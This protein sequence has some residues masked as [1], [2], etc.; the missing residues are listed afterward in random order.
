MQQRSTQHGPRRRWPLAVIGGIAAT[1]IG[2]AWWPGLSGGHPSRH[3]VLDGV[4][5]AWPTEGES[6]IAVNGDP[7]RFSRPAT[8]RLPI[9][10]VAKVMTAYVVL[11]RYPLAIGA[12]GF[13]MVMSPADA[14]L[15]VTDSAEGQ[16]FVPVQAGEELTE[17]DALEALLLPSANNIAMALASYTSGSVDAFVAEMNAQAATLHMTHTTYT[18]P[19]GYADTTVSTARDQLKLAQVVTKNATFAQIVAMPAAVVP[20]VGTVKNTNTLLGRDGF[21][22]GKTGSDSA[23]GGCF[24]FKAVRVIG[25]HRY[26]F[27]GV[28]LGQHNGPLINAGLDAADDLVDSVAMRLAAEQPRQNAAARHRR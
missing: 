28:V 11:R 12:D 20:F 9:A 1:A 16:S 2:V 14:Q 7:Q 10:S 18:D 6:A 19:S 22:G 23:A 3:A 26:T 4:H 24:M 8:E 21:V 25:G 15:S 13:T 17:R 5:I 27:L